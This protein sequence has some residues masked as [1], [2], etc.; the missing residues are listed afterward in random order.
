MSSGK[1]NIFFAHQYSDTRIS[2]SDKEQAL[3][4]AVQAIQSKELPNSEYELEWQNFELDT[5][6]HI[7]EQIIDIIE[8]S[9]IFIADI[10]QQNPNVIFELGVAYGFQKLADKHLIWIAHEETDVSNIPSDLRG[11]YIQKYNYN[12]LKSLLERRIGVLT[13]EIID[14]REDYDHEERIKRYWGELNNSS[15]DLV[16]SEI[17]DQEKPDFASPTHINY[18][19][20][21]KFADLDSLVYLKSAFT[22]YYPGSHIR[23]FTHSE[24]V[25]RDA[26]IQIVIGGPTWNTKTREIL[27]RFP[28]YFDRCQDSDYDS[29]TIEFNELEEYE[30]RPK[31]EGELNGREG[32]MLSDVSLYGRINVSQDRSVYLVAGCTTYGV[33][34]ASQCLLEED[35]AAQNAEYLSDKTEGRDFIMMFESDIV[36]QLVQ[37]PDFSLENP[38]VI[39]VRDNSGGFNIDTTD[40]K[41][42]QTNG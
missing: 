28:C 31:I 42:Y 21:A 13:K 27:S 36:G 10:S 39:A 9:D 3:I 6:T 11:L 17:P 4:D 5:G 19:R 41:E 16:C 40:I 14:V 2:K 12:N 15:I 26:K 23:H 37:V 33:Y 30:F 18:L 25:N 38:L 22:K 20:Y 7:G 8:T 24:Y 34:G 35:V 1:I 32:R 29:V